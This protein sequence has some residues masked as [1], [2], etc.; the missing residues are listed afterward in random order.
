MDAVTFKCLLCILFLPANIR[1][2]S[3]IWYFL[4]I[5]QP[6]RGRISSAVSSRGQRSPAASH[7]DA[8]WFP[9]CSQQ[10]KLTGP[11]FVFYTLLFEAKRM[12]PADLRAEAE[13]FYNDLSDKW[14][15]GK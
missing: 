15:T 4:C 1:Q 11:P 14:L 9:D 13:M 2:T 5:V 3:H 7:T 6:N 8:V 10:R 12:Q